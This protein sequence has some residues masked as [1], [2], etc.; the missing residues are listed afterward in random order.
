MWGGERGTS[1]SV[2]KRVES[3]GGWVWL[4]SCVVRALWLVSLSTLSIPVGRSTAANYC[5]ADTNPRSKW[6]K[7]EGGKRRKTREIS[8]EQTQTQMGARKRGGVVKK[9]SGILRMIMS[10][11][12]GR[13]DQMK[14]KQKTGFQKARGMEGIRCTYKRQKGKTSKE[15]NISRSI[16]TERCRET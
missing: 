2:A 9:H 7:T 13:G 5:P 8:S 4:G 10:S 11:L 3:L 6:G 1:L 15:S 12:G 16:P 14:R